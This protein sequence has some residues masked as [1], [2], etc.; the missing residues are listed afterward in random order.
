MVEKEREALFHKNVSLHN[1]NSSINSVKH[2]R[3]A[4][5]ATD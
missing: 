2:I 3:I 5:L 4:L 1:Q